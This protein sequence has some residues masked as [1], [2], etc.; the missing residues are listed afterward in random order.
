MINH[1][2]NEP[3]DLFDFD[4]TAKAVQNQNIIVR[5]FHSWLKNDLRIREQHLPEYHRKA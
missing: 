4:P 5:N 2:L 3:E 1:M